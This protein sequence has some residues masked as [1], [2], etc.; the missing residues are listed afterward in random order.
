M[1]MEKTEEMSFE[2]AMRKLGFLSDKIEK[3]ELSLDEAMEIYR[4]ALEL[5]KVCNSR[6]TAAEQQVK[7][8]SEKEDGTAE[9][10]DFKPSAGERMEE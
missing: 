9:I 7:L 5:V 1:S 6:L 3:G 4:Q 2:E 8:I 10:T